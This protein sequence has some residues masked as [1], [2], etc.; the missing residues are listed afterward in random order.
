MFNSKVA[1]S[2]HPQS[3]LQRQ[4]HTRS[5]QILCIA[6]S[7]PFMKIFAVEMLVLVSINILRL[8]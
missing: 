5:A 7:V 4:R 3:G 1:F 8:S 6:N 2:K